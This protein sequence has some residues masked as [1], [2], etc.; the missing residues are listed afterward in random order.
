M[1][2]VTGKQCTF[3][4]GSD[5]Y[6]GQITG[7][8]ASAEKSVET[9]A[10]WGADHVYAGTPSFSLSVESLFFS[11]DESLQAAVEA[12]L[13]ANTPVT[14]VVDMGAATRT[15][16]NYLVSTY[17]D[18]APADGVITASIGFTGPALFTT[19]YAAS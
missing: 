9:V 2:V 19:V 15:Y 13:D 6:D 14:I 18:D 8:S 10:A 12:A 3:T 7:A 1:S 16:T 17:S 11:D 5:S 4:I